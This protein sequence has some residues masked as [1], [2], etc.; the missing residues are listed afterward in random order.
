MVITF[1]SDDAWNHFV[2]QGFVYT[3]R[4]NRRKAFMKLEAEGRVLVGVFDWT[5]RGR[6]KPKEADVTIH[7]IGEMTPSDLVDY[8]EWSGFESWQKWFDEIQRLN[9]F[10]YSVTQKGW[11]YKVALHNSSR[12]MTEN[13]HNGEE[14]K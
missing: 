9:N 14:V 13:N 10:N 8:V 1:T 12:T 2:D 7:E 5:S 11:L 6:G 3:F 4:K